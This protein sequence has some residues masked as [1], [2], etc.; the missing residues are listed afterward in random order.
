MTRHLITFSGSDYDATT[1]RIVESAPWCGADEIYIFDDVWMFEQDFTK[2]HGN[3]WLW[4]HPHPR[5]VGFCAWKP[6]LLT[7]MFD[8][9]KPGDSVVYTDADAPPVASLAPIFEIAERDGAWLSASQ[10]HKQS[11]WCKRD[12]YLTMGHSGPLEEQAGCARF[13]ALRKGA[14]REQQLLAEWLTYSCNRYANSKDPSVLSGNEYPDF[15]Q[16]RDEQAIL[17][18]LAHKNKIKLHRE[19]DQ[20]GEDPS[21]FH[22]DRELYGQ[23]FEQVHST[24][25]NNGLGSKYRRVPA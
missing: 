11:K 1:K 12:A 2:L 22:V 16:H 10:G 25:G 4:E 3:R 5:C 17:T 23:L 24:R 21:C 8:R 20:T 14:W 9:M 18:N 13:L 6:F 19:A 7:Y 15:E